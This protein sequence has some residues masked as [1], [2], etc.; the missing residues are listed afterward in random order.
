MLLIF[1]SQRLRRHVP[2]QVRGEEAPPL[3]GHRLPRR[4]PRRVGLPGPTPR[5]TDAVPAGLGADP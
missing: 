1:R 2:G 3:H 5:G 4:G